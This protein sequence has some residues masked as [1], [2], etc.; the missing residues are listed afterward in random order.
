[1]SIFSLPTISLTASEESGT[2]YFEKLA[3]LLTATFWVSN[4]KFGCKT[5]FQ[6]YAVSTENILSLNSYKL[7]TNIDGD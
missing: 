2:S 5:N 6:G 1:V 4:L 7:R 3:F